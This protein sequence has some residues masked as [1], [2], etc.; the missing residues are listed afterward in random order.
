[1]VLL[2]VHRT[3]VGASL[4]AMTDSMSPKIQ[5]KVGAFG[6]T[7]S[8]T[9]APRNCPSNCSII[10]AQPWRLAC[11]RA[12]SRTQRKVSRSSSSHTPH[13]RTPL[14]PPASPV[15]RCSHGEYAEPLLPDRRP[16][17]PVP[18][19]APQAPHCRRFR[20]GSETETHPPTH[21]DW[22][23]LR[24]VVSRRKSPRAV[25]SPVP[26]VAGRRRSR[27]ASGCAVD[28]WLSVCRSCA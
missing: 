9:Q 17:H 15:R 28:K 21:S 18:R 4:L 27:S 13:R 1:M 12:L 20:S 3:T 5:G 6:T 10:A 16:P 2:Y 23:R 25:P 24:R 26:L 11:W 7:S 14:H 19:P 22:P 8:P